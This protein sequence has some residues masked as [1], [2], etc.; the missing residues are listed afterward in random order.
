M[1]LTKATQAKVGPRGTLNAVVGGTFR[2]QDAELGHWH[3]TTFN[4]SRNAG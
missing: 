3:G 1:D 2:T 4:T